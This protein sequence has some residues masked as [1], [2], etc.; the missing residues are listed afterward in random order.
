LSAGAFSTDPDRNAWLLNWFRI[1]GEVLEAIKLAI[2]ACVLFCPK[3]CEYLKLLIGHSTPIFKRDAEGRKLLLHPA[4][5]N[6]HD[7]TTLRE[8]LDGDGYACPVQRMPVRK[9]Q[10][11]DAKADPLRAACQ[12]CQAGKRIEERPVRRD[13]KLVILT[14]WVRRVDLPGSDDSIS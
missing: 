14:I 9:Y 3:M 6:A 2:E 10:D 7:E 13:D 11:A 5:S 1:E 12:K 8:L 4:H